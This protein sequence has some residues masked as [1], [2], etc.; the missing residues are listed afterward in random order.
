MVACHRLRSVM[1]PAGRWPLGQ[2]TC[3]GASSR[4]Y[5]QASSEGGPAMTDP[6]P[7]YTELLAERE[8]AEVVEPDAGKDPQQDER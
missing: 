1:P 3:L 5:Q 8:A 4:G 6:N 7:I 2:P